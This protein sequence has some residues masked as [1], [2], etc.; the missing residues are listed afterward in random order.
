MLGVKTPDHKRDPWQKELVAA[1]VSAG[2][3]ILLAA[4][5][6]IVSESYEAALPFV[7]PSMFVSSAS[8]LWFGLRARRRGEEAGRLPA[9]IGAIVGGFYLAMLLIGR[10]AHLLFEIE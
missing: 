6:F 8:A 1:W 7:V 9:M 10:I 2:T 4:A 5:I 3:A